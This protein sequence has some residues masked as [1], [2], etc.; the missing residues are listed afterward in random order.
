MAKKNSETLNEEAAAWF[1]RL[2]APNIAP[3]HQQAFDRWMDVPENAVAYI[4]VEAA[5]DRAERLRALPV[6]PRTAVF[7]PPVMGITRRAAA[8]AG[9]FIGA[10]LTAAMLFHHDAAFATELGERKTIKLADGS[11]VHLNT[12]S[13]IEVDFRGKHRRI[14]LITGEALFDVAKD[15]T[16]PFIVMAGDACVKALGT[17]FN[18]R[19]REASVEVTVAEG[20]VSVD[21]VAKTAKSGISSKVER[22]TAGGAAVVG[23][24]AVGELALDSDTLQRRVVWTEGVIDLHG[25]TLEQAVA[26]FNRYSETKLVVGDPTLA[27]IRVGGTFETNGANEFV[28]AL[29]AGFGVRAVHGENAIYLLPA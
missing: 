19:L 14:R 5:W 9:L 2:Q 13:R 17:Q 7:T 27:A 22:M 15:P 1:V 26:E 21:A 25:E 11:R 4:R 3:A 12:A 16:R 18:V 8:A 29:E 28:S 10:G 6:P 24:G 20:A 23:A